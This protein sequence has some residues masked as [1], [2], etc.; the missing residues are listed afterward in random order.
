MDQND[1]ITNQNVNDILARLASFSQ[2]NSDQFLH[3]AS[4]H[5]N[6]PP[7]TLRPH[8]SFVNES[9][10]QAEYSP[11]SHISPPSFSQQQ[12]QPPSTLNDPQP[13]TA[14]NFLDHLQ[15]LQQITQ[16]AKASTSRPA[17]PKAAYDPN[18]AAAAAAAGGNR[19]GNYVGSRGPV[20]TSH[21]YS[22]AA[23]AGSIIEWAPALRHVSKVGARNPELE[24]TVRKVCDSVVGE[25]VADGCSLPRS[26]GRMRIVGGS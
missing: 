3:Q 22:A 10:H 21:Y 15:R 1:P 2:N 7:P 18:G 24:G 25:I 23:A 12:H 13:T 8:S 4:T 11:P 17:T 16:E 20:P 19:S 6:N 5:S 9:P 26:R 14:P